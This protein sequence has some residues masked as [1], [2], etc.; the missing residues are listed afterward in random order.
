MFSKNNGRAEGVG[1]KVQHA[2]Q[3]LKRAWTCT[4]AVALGHGQV[5]KVRVCLHCSTLLFAVKSCWRSHTSF[6]LPGIGPI[7]NAEQNG[8]RRFALLVKS[9]KA[10]N[11][12]LQLRLL[13]L[14]ALGLSGQPQ[15]EM[16]RAPVLNGW[17][18]SNF[19]R[20]LS[21]STDIPAFR[22]NRV[23]PAASISPS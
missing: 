17:R 13:D 4:P 3:L 16:K 10:G 21:A 9:R 14:R 18:N 19:S 8:T 7:D 15:K 20:S 1:R 12:Y 23:L 5:P 6:F 2:L 22:A 11:E